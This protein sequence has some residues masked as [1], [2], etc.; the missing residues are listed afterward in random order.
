[1]AA[2]VLA[3]IP[4]RT[5]PLPE[6]KQ[7]LQTAMLKAHK[8][9]IIES[10][11]IWE[12]P[13]APRDFNRNSIVAQFLKDVPHATHLLFVDDDTALPHDAVEKL[14]A[15]DK[16]VAVGV[17][18]LYMG[19]DNMVANVSTGCPDLQPLGGDG[20]A[21]IHWHHWNPQRAPF[22]VGACG[23]GCVLIRRDVLEC[24]ALDKT[25]DIN[26]HAEVSKQCTEWLLSPPGVPAASPRP[27]Q[28]PWFVEFYGN[29]IGHK[30]QTEDIWF[31]RRAHDAGVEI[32]VDPSIVCA[33]LKRANIGDMMPR[34]A[35]EAR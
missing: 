15:L 1:M 26:F 7:S 21:W 23:F 3:S 2:R 8:A 22:R 11:G 20:T 31:C 19:P 18:P 5:T 27:M 30:V 28:W 29:A 17:Q 10:I 12:P 24:P 25:Y 13:A 6:C 34:S 35:V 9:D 14:I 4:C 32:W 16:P 33:H